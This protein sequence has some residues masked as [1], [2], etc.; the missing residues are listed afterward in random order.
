MRKPVSLSTSAL[1]LNNLRNSLI[2]AEDLAIPYKIAANHF[3]D[4]NMPQISN[5]RQFFG[6]FPQ[7]KTVHS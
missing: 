4:K 6:D 5:G 3:A 1:S 7:V 2:F